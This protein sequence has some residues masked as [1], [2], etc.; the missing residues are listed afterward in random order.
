MSSSP[1][2]AAAAFAQAAAF[3]TV[4][5]KLAV[6]STLR[7]A[8]ALVQWLAAPSGTML[9]GCDALAGI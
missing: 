9:V 4:A 5:G 8:W 2:R 1:G 7:R 6:S 3:I